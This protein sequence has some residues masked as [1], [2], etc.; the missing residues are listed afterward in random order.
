MQMAKK[1]LKIVVAGDVTIDWFMYPVKA[2][3]EGYNWRLHHSSHADVLP[4]GAALLTNFIEQ[5]LNEEGILATVRGP[6]LPE[7]QEL[8]NFSSDEVIHSNVMLENSKVLGDKTAE[9]LRIK[10]FFGYIGPENKLPSWVPESNDSNADIIVLDDAGNGFREM[11]NV[12]PKDL[13]SVGDSIIVYKMSLPLLK[14]SLWKQINEKTPENLIVIINSNDLRRTAGIHISKS[15]SWERTAKD[16]VFELQRSD[17][18]NSLQ[19]CPY[20]VVLFDTDGAIL[21]HGR[22]DDVNDAVIVFDPS[23]L[24]GSFA[25]NID[26]TMMGLMS[27]FTAT[28]VKQISKEGLSGLTTGIKQGLANSRALLEAGYKKDHGIEY[29]GLEEILEKNAKYTYV[30]S[31][32]EI[33]TNLKDA[34][35]RFWR[36]L[37]HKTR[38]VRQL[39]AR[40]IVQKGM[41]KGLESV[42][43]CKFGDLETIDRAEIESYSSIKELIIE[44]LLNQKP[45]NPLCFA[46]FGPP[47]SGK[48][49]GVKQVLKSIDSNGVRLESISFN[50]SQLGDYQDLVNAFHKVRDIAL[51]GKVPFVFFDEFDSACE[52]QPLGWLKY[53][54]APMQDGEFREGETVHPIGNAIFVFAGGT[55]DT[56]EDF[57][58][59]LHN[60]D[61]TT[62]LA[63]Y[64]G[65]NADQNSVQN[66]EI[67]DADK[68]FRDA[69]GPDFVSRLRGFINVMGPNRQR[70]K[71]DDDDAFIIRRAQVLRVLLENE[72]TAS[73]LFNSKKEISIDSGVLRAML[74]VTK[75]KHGTRSMTALIEMSRLAG[76]NR[77][78]LSALPVKKQ[79][80]MHVDADEFLFLTEKER[81]QSMLRLKDLPNPEEVSYRKREDTVVE[82]VAKFM[83]ESQIS[84]RKSEGKELEKDVSFEEF[85]DAAEDIPN[86]L[87]AIN[88]GIRKI[89]GTIPHTPDITEDEIETFAR[90]EYERFCRNQRLGG[91]SDSKENK[92][93]TGIT[94]QLT[95]FN[96]LH[97]D[98]KHNFIESVY[99]IPPVLQKAGYEIYRMK[100][101]EE[102][103][104]PYIID[105]L[106]RLLHDKYVEKRKIK[107]DTPETNPSLVEFDALPQDLKEAN[108][109]SARKIPEKLSWVGYKIR[110]LQKNDEQKETMLTKDEIEKMANREHDRWVWQKIMQGW[111]YKEG[112]KNFE[113]KTTPCIVPWNKLSPGIRDNDRNSVLLIPKLLEE[114]GYKAYKPNSAKNE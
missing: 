3:D 101:F 43:I 102:I 24:E 19:Q 66:T 79:L 55:R 75:Y 14:G 8:R 39:V 113:N 49:F 78:D 100:D 109:D 106:A 9:V 16:F 15:L 57:V 111:V 47:G 36:I 21:Y 45:K 31:S 42:P 27:I 107:G 5:S 18:L 30:C 91:L 64:E 90:F 38:N 77:F 94:P 37:D 11:G 28:L 112:E 52:G 110:R 99:A 105:R 82:S 108:F 85:K 34:D 83:H 74:N 51:S 68:K 67:K 2:S 22:K 87:W 88:H 53:F 80:D 65:Q 4:G 70:T 44:F 95:P 48:S 10:K 35:P 98:I 69:K 7:K 32:V 1:E 93:C 114:A 61:S 46:V 97:K 59:N 60:N 73:G 29:P 62:N 71:D 104:D 72:Q 12:W 41:A 86:K 103:N 63:S 84:H 58:K 23:L 92:I 33:P 20:L 40:E 81:Y 96:K 76:K 6:K 89:V 13:E 54:L 17:A 50:V 25:S 56:F 26:G